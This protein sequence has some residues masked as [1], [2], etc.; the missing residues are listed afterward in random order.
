MRPL[1]LLI[2]LGTL[3]AP[4]FATAGEESYYIGARNG[5]DV[6]DAPRTS[7]K[8]LGRL[9]RMADVKVL[10]KRR[11][12]WKVEALGDESELLGWVREGAVRKR[13]QPGVR[14]KVTSSAFAAFTSLFSRSA[15]QQQTAVLGVRGLEDEGGDATASQQ[16]QQSAKEMV[17][18]MEGLK[19]EEQEVAD[20]VQEGDLNP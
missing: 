9:E 6:L 4:A 1:I 2:A 7:A 12:W 10:Q 17:Q 14:K 18:W 13:Y 11:A 5:V 20:F 16:T 19:V 8:A 15:P 3:F